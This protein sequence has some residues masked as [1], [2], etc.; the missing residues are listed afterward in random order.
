MSSVMARPLRE[1]ST[2]G[3][4]HC[5]SISSLWKRVY[6]EIDQYIS[7]FVCLFSAKIVEMQVRPP[8]EPVNFRLFPV[9]FFGSLN[10]WTWTVV[11]LRVIDESTRACLDR[12]RLLTKKYALT[13]REMEI[14]IG[15]AFFVSIIRHWKYPDISS[16]LEF[17]LGISS[18]LSLYFDYNDRK[19]NKESSNVGKKFKEN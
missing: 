14:W 11:V 2:S 19:V 15:S 9:K 6:I 18:S 1:I 8:R 17:F 4:S 7:V 10:R 12:A 13:E 16:I 3:T 5:N